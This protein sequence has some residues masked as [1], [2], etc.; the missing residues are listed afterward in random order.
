M[1]AVS[2]PFFKINGESMERNGHF[3]PFVPK[4]G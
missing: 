2:M 1:R 3:K 4:N